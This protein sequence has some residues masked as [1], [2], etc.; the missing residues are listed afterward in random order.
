MKELSFKIIDVIAPKPILTEAVFNGYVQRGIKQQADFCLRVSGDSMIGARIYDGDIVFIRQQPTVAS[1][2]IAA[3]IL[4][5]AVI[6]R[7]VYIYPGSIEL[8]AENPQIK[9]LVFM[10]FRQVKILGKA[11]SFQGNVI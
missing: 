1:G 9:P 3:V 7:R 2:E 8:R 10:D 5:G 6:L 11:I 4:N